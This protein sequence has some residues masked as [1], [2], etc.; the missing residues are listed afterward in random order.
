VRTFLLAWLSAR[1]GGGAVVLRVEDLDPDRCRPEY[2]ARLIE[3]LRWLGFDWDEGPDT[4]GPHAPYLQSRRTARY[5][6][7]LTRLVAAGLAYPCV[8]SR[9]EV[10]AAAGAPHGPGGTAYPGTCRDRFADA[11]DAR[12]RA[13]R[14]P[15][16]RFDGRRVPAVPW[17]DAFRPDR[18]MPAAVDDFVL[19]R[20]DDV[21][22]YQLAVVVDDL[23]M[24][25]TEVVRGEDLADST[26][27]Q[28]ALIQALGGVPPAYAHVPLVLDE[29]G[30]RLA[31]R[32]GARQ[33]AA[34]RALGVRPEQVI[35][36]LAWGLGLHDRPE[37]VPLAALVAGFRWQA[38]RREPVRIDEQ[39]L[40]ALAAP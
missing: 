6:E 11:D 27:R 4:G 19:W 14:P 30:Q 34:L 18:A 7:A 10:A 39:L 40:R 21:P 22:A 28:L 35:G 12:R 2:T 8:C 32:G 17:R 25:V 38:V 16:W 5:R 33:I 23:A 13:G 1:A 15:C 3:D 9:A 26:P 20:A 24:A 29:T 36:L 37:P 31:K